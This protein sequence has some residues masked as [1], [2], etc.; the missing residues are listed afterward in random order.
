MWPNSENIAEKLEYKGVHGRLAVV[1]NLETHELLERAFQP[2]NFTWIGLRYWCATKRLQFTDGS[3]WE[4]GNFHAWAQ[5]WDQSH[6]ADPCGEWH[7]YGKPQFM[8]VAY[9]PMA[10]GFRWNAREWHKGFPLIIVEFP[11]GKP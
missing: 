3:Y 4:P 7:V 11:T 1:K 5:T 2:T 6:L 8:P 9:S 10:E